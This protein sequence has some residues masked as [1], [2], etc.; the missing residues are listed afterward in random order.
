MLGWF[1]WVAELAE[2][3]KLAFLHKAYLRIFV[4]QKVKRE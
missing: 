2:I 4:G 3:C 1:Y